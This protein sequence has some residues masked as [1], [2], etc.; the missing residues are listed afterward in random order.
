MRS[1]PAARH[2]A[3]VA[4]TLATLAALSGCARGPRTPEEAYARL[5]EA[6]SQQ[7]GQLLFA[8]VDQDTRWAWMS[9]QRS[10]REAYDIVLSNFPAGARERALRRFEEGA[11]AESAAALFARRAAKA[12]L[13][14]FG[15]PLPAQP[16]FTTDGAVATTVLPSGRKLEF[17]RV[18]RRSGWGYAGLLAEAKDLE[19][20]AFA[21]LEQA[22]TS[23]TDYERAAVRSGQP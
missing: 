16:T 2:G 9:V 6:V 11:L 18:S 17:R 14:S 23:A 1:C 21:D 7:D 19:R 22:R 13:S 10:Q 15:G 5:S 20:R 3:A 4:V 12:A 8:A